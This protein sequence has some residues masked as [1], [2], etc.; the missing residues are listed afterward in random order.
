MNAG[1]IE[2]SKR[3][4]KTLFALG[5]GPKT[6]K[7]LSKITGSCAVHSDM[8][9]LKSNGIA[10]HCCYVNRSKNGSKVYQYSLV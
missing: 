2:T 5:S 8:S 4:Q 1:H 3:L 7:Q 6:T 10:Y 9:A